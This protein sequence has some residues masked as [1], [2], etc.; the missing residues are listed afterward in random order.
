MREN[1]EAKNRTLWYGLVEALDKTSVLFLRQLKGDGT[2]AWELL[3]KRYKF[4]ERKRLKKFIAQLTSLENTSSESI[5]EYLTR[6]DDV[7]YKLTPVNEGGISKKIFVSIILKELPKEI[8]WF[9][10]LVKCSK[11][12]KTLEEINRDLI[13][14]DNKYLKTNIKSVFLIGNGI[15]ST[16]TKQDISQKTEGLRKQFMNK[17]TLPQ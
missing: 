2:G 7:Q 4:F 3:C 14:F 11:D 8:E 12:N 13:N 9:A 16:A 15:A 10:T 1:I 6:A 5:V 17:P